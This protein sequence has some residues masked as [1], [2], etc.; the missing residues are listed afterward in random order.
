MTPS[1]VNHSVKIG[2]AKQLHKICKMLKS[3]VKDILFKF[4]NNL[5]HVGYNL[6][7]A[8]PYFGNS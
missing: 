6:L 8:F 5:I 3:L 2:F 4:L 1:E 7:A